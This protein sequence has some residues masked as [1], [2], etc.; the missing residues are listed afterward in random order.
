M[1][2]EVTVTEVEY[3]RPQDHL[4]PSLL[5]GPRMLEHAGPSI[6]I[7]PPPVEGKAPAVA[8][9]STD[10]DTDTMRHKISAMVPPYG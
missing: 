10:T 4:G 2:E 9:N 6:P 5:Y 7:P 3:L 1:C 8:R